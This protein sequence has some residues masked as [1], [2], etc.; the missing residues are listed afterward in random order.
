MD[1]YFISTIAIVYMINILSSISGIGGSILL[2]PTYILVAKLDIHDAV[3]LSTIT[4]AGSTLVRLLYYFPKTYDMPTRRY[5]V[6]YKTI[7][8]MFPFDAYLAYIGVIINR[9]A[10]S[11]I[12]IILVLVIIFI[13]FI[14]TLRQSYKQWKGERKIKDDPTELVIINT[15]PDAESHSHS[16]S[17]STTESESEGNT[18]DSCIMRYIS[19]GIILAVETVIIGFSVVR[20]VLE[21]CSPAFWVIVGSQIVVLFFIG[22]GLSCYVIHRHRR[23]V[24]RNIKSVKSDISWNIRRAILFAAFSSL[25]G[26]ISTLLGG[27]GGMFKLPFLLYIGME[28]R[29]ASATISVSTFFTSTNSLIQY[30]LTGEIL[31]TYAVTMSITAMAGTLNGLLLSNCIFKRYGKQFF[32]A[33]I[34]GILLFL[35]FVALTYFNVTSIINGREYIN[36]PIC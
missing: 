5:I 19:L 26:F 20:E 23:E 27:G 30:A 35:S 9:L 6:D 18:G 15:E 10:P 34:F 2:I 14:Q 7:I 8:L 28:P 21:K 11:W 3:P 17:D 32:I 25:V 31:W 29:I 36:E 22:I 16:S 13:L 24:N 12:I 4:V 1:I 33:L